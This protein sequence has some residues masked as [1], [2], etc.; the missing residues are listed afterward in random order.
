MDLTWNPSC[1]D[2]FHVVYGRQVK[3]LFLNFLK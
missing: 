1:L 2:L 3:D